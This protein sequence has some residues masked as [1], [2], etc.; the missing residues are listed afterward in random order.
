MVAT[1][2][3]NG[4]SRHSRLDNTRKL[5][6]FRSII[7]S[8]ACVHCIEELQNLTYATDRDGEIIPDEFN[9]AGASFRAVC[10]LSIT[11]ARGRASH[12]MST[13]RMFLCLRVCGM[14]IGKRNMLMVLS[15]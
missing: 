3:S 4:G 2:K 12:E 9:R 15:C 6:R 13:G 10:M 8:D 11:R 1:K 14:R 7:C 5:K